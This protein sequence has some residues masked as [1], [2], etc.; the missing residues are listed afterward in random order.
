MNRRQYAQRRRDPISHGPWDWGWPHV[1]PPSN[2]ALYTV[3]PSSALYTVEPS[4]TGLETL[5]ST[6]MLAFGPFQYEW[7]ASM[8]LKCNQTLT[9][10][11]EKLPFC[12]PQF[13]TPDLEKPQV[14]PSHEV[15][16]DVEQAIGVVQCS[17]QIALFVVCVG[18]G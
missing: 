3:E 13:L 14:Q 17:V 7:Q 11:L 16:G 8:H 12:S 2:S 18:A 10:D 15:R 4:S 6:S 5:L 9:P 1:L